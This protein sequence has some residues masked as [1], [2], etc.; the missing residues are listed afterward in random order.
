MRETGAGRWSLALAVLVVLAAFVMPRI[1]ATPQAALAATPRVSSADDPV[2]R[3]R[4]IIVTSACGYCHG[5]DANP[6]SPDWLQGMK[7]QLN[8]FKIGPC[9]LKPDAMPCFH[10]RP[11]NLTPDNLTGMG[12]FSERQIFNALRYGLRPE[13]TPDVEITSSTPGVGN[14]PEHPHYLA[15]PMPWPS[16]R[17]KPD[18]DLWAIAAYLKRGLKPV[19]NKVPDSEG[20]PDFWASEYT[21]EKIGPYPV[22]AFPT[23]NERM[24]VAQAGS[25]PK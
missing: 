20:P 25:P 24:P 18:Q 16:W 19:R 23:A 9:A 8:E 4:A 14:F 2:A 1:V 22:P 21:V 11:R 3:G 13:D 10:T 17:Q 12:R 15:P 5:G 7:T 6:A